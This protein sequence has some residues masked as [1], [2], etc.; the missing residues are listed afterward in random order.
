MQLIYEW[1]KR[2]FSDPQLVVLLLLLVG[3]FAIII[4]MGDMLAPLLASLVIAYLLE[5]LTGLMERR[6][7]P[8][9]VAVLM[10]FSLFMV[11]LALILFGL[12]PLL[13]KQVTELLQQLPR[14]LSQ[15]QQALMALPAKYPELVSPEQINNVINALGSEIGNMGQKILSA[16]LSSVVGLI[17]ILV[18]LVLVP[19][20]VFFFLKDKQIIVDWISD[21]LPNERLIAINV[22][23]EVDGQIANYVRGKFWEI[24]VVWSASLLTFTFLGLQYA[25]LLG[26]LVGLSVIVPY[27]GAT[28]VTFP[29]LL[30]GWFQWGWGADL[31][32]LAL[33]YL[34]I[35]ALDG[36]VL[37]PLL[38][39]E[40][41]SLHP[42]AIILAIL[43]FGGFWGLWGVFFAIPLATLVN[44][45]LQ[46]WPTRRRM[47]AAGLSTGS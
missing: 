41:V 4:T 36:N 1:F 20:L 32:W 38:F 27:I 10:V 23:K 3:G 12:M 26:L 17:T 47:E 43:V 37:V 6:G 29:V 5:G 39:S 8:R 30:V 16:S 21:R 9:M 44:A 42:V 35:Q 28:L 34:I 40:V 31:G 7:V 19:L 14:M 22:W 13:Y 18:Y 25:M 46:A 15:G 45:V 11:A 33:V 24:I 2:T